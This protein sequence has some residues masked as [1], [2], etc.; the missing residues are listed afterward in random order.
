MLSNYKMNF[1]IISILI[2]IQLFRSYYYAENSEYI[3]SDNITSIEIGV[4][5]Q[6]FM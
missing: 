1:R 5:K 6:L 2:F 3:I 4:T